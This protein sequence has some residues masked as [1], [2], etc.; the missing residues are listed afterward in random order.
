ML[1]GFVN[2]S[3][4]LEAVRIRHMQ[5]LRQAQPYIYLLHLQNIVFAYDM[6]RIPPICPL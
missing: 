6:A 3:D 1:C 4:D 2:F 5:A